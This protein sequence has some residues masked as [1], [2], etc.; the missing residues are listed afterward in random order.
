MIRFD[1]VVSQF[2]ELAPP[3]LADWIARGWVEPE[4]STRADWQFAEIDVAR[5]RLICEL[6]IRMEL[7]EEALALVLP[8]LDQIYG[9]RATLQAM[10]RALDDQPPA[11]RAAVLAAISPALRGGA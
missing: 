8:L 2:P 5:I 9:L 1:A 10:L 4:G 11:V 3:E 7:D 6:R